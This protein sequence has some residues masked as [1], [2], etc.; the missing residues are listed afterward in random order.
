MDAKRKIGTP[1]QEALLGLSEQISTIYREEECSADIA[2]DAYLIQDDRFICLQAS[3]AGREAWVPLEIGTEG[4][5]DT[6]RARLIYE[7][8]RVVR[9]RL[10]LE[11]YT[12]EY[13]KAQ[14]GKVIDAYR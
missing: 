7:V 8:T 10:D 12:G 1:Y 11:R 3:I 14:V 13:V 4:W 6:R 5:S 2:V 9:K